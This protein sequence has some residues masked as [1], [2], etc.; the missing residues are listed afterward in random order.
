MGSEH[1]VVILKKAEKKYVDEAVVLYKELASLER[2]NPRD[3]SILQEWMQ[4]PSMGC[5]YLI[6]RD[7]N[8]WAHGEDLVACKG[9]KVDNQF[10][11]GW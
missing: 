10:S 9:R 4:R 11:P 6:G 1:D 8:I 3:L 2:P 7:R 5:V